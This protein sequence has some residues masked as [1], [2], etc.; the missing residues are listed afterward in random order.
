MVWESLGLLR[1]GVEGRQQERFARAQHRRRQCQK[2]MER[3]GFDSIGGPCSAL[4]EF[5][6]FESGDA[7]SCQVGASEV[8]G[9]CAYNC[10]SPRRIAPV[11]I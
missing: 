7:S 9:P 8:K 10:Q 6:G 4:C 3:E 1:L 5:R 2:G 11:V